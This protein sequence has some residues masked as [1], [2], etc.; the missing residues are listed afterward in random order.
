MFLATFMRTS[1]LPAYGAAYF[2]GCHS[3]EENINCHKK[4][5]YDTY[6]LVQQLSNSIGGIFAFLSA[7]LV[8][9]L[10]DTKGRKPFLY[11]QVILRFIPFIF[12]IIYNNVFIFLMLLSL[13]GFNGS[14]YVITPASNSYMSD[15]IPKPLRIHAFGFKYLLSGFGLLFG[16]STGYIIAMLFSVTIDFYVINLLY[17]ISLIYLYFFIKESLITDTGNTNNGNETTITSEETTDEA[18]NY[19]NRNPFAPLKY[20]CYNKIVFNIAMVNAF[21]SL[22]ETGM[23]DISIV[24]LSDLFDANSSQKGNTIALLFVLGWAFGLILISAVT[25]PLL[26]KIFSEVNILFINLGCLCFACLFMVFFVLIPYMFL[27][28]LIGI[29]FAHGALC[30]AALNSIQSKYCSPKEQGISFGVVF[31]MR[32]IAGIIAPFAFAIGY[33]FLKQEG[34]PTMIFVIAIALSLIAV[35]F[36]WRLKRLLIQADNERN[37]HEFGLL[38]TEMDDHKHNHNILSVDDNEDDNEDMVVR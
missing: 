25:L 10:S 12:I 9:N 38:M 34:F 1:F 4:F 14:M 30:V 23:V 17:L 21:V 28:P 27:I 20:L 32:A 8:G 18:T 36:A 19:S 13:V 11:M 15:I 16:T 31:A 6:N 35:V 22:T 24:V 26:K 2:G 29:C 3:R 5:D 7:S 33:H 37:I